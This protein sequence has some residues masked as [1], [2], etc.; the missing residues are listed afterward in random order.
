MK[1]IE[2][3]CTGAGQYICTMEYDITARTFRSALIFYGFTK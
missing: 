2:G 3:Y 1:K